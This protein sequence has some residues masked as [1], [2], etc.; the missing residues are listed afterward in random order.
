MKNEFTGV[1]WPHILGQWSHVSCF[2]LSRTDRGPTAKSSEPAHTTTL[3]PGAGGNAGAQARLRP[4]V[5]VSSGLIPRRSLGPG[6]LDKLCPMSLVASKIGTIYLQTGR[7]LSFPLYDLS[8]CVCLFLAKNINSLAK[9]CGNKRG[10][11]AEGACGM[12]QE[13]WPR[14]C[15]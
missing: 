15:F 6:Q 3:M 1:R 4:A 12:K 10:G 11:T 5:M 13:T 8:W 2:L 14:W 9:G 7:C